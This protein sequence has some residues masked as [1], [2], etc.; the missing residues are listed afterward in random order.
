MRKG[1]RLNG[2]FIYVLDRKG[3]FAVAEARHPDLK[4]PY[5]TDLLRRGRAYGAGE[6]RITDGR[7][8]RV[9][10]SSGHFR[11][12]A[13]QILAVLDRLVAKGVSLDDVAV[14]FRRR[15]PKS[16]GKPRIVVS[17]QDVVAAR[18]MIGA[19]IR[20]ARRYGRSRPWA[21]DRDRDAQLRRILDT[22]LVLLSADA[23]GDSASAG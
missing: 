7:L 19:C 8:T 1:E 2:A 12:G 5:H 9:S 11:P 13:A 21:W 15:V 23:S 17:A 14:S 10:D 4:R 20:A 22:P 3:R 6:F 18:S 16:A